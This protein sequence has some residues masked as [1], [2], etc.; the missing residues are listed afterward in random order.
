METVAGDSISSDLIAEVATDTR[1][2]ELARFVGLVNE[3]KLRSI[4]ASGVL[5]KQAATIKGID[6]AKVRGEFPDGL[7]GHLGVGV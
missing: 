6:V 1:N 5:I 7:F 2:A 3:D 4:D